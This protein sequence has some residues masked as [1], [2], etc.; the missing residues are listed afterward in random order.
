MSCKCLDGEN[1]FESLR[2]QGENLVLRAQVLIVL[3][4]KRGRAEWRRRR[5]AAAAFELQAV[6]ELIGVHWFHAA[7]LLL[8]RMQTFR[9]VQLIGGRHVGLVRVGQVAVEL[10]ARSGQLVGERLC[11]CVGERLLLD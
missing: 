11:V 6:R 7:V 2:Q 3:E 5:A 9:R 4:V 10:D 1:I 8:A